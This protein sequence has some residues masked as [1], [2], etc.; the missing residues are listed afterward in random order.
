MFQKCNFI[1]TV[2]V[3]ALTKLLIFRSM[4]VHMM[5]NNYYCKKAYDKLLDEYQHDN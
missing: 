1:Y 3:I 2:I 5:Y 4:H